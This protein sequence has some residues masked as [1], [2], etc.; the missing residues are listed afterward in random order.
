[1]YLTKERQSI[2]LDS[3]QAEHLSR[4]S[5]INSIGFRLTK[6]SFSL[7]SHKWFEMSCRVGLTRKVVTGL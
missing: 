4:K 7:F 3:M 1:M 6:E 5:G 2:D